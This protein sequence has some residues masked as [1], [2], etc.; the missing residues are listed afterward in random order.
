MTKKEL[1]DFITAD[2]TVSGQLKLNLNE[3]EIERIIDAETKHAYMNWR[4]AVDLQTAVINPCCFWSSEY[5]K[6][7]TIQLPECVYGIH[8]FKEIKDGSRLF[9]INDPN[10]NMDRIMGADMWL[11][12]FSSDVIS[13]RTINYSWFDLA[14]SF[15]L[16]DIQHR[17]NIATHRLQVIG[18]EPRCPVI[19][20][21]FIGIDL[22]ALYEYYYFQRWCIARCKCQMHR[23]LKTFEANAI[24]GVNITSMY[25]EHGKEEMTEIKEYMEK[26]DPADYF[27]MVN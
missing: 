15:T 21:A 19:I 14:R 25:G 20:R 10:L 3:P 8:T 11:S 17:F 5:K 4:D 24:G 12:P 26:V 18:R 1:V 23:V 9:G 22:D 27:L 2:L 7:R 6:T 16:T 13:S